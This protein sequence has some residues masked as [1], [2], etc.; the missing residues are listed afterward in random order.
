M[1][2]RLLIDFVNNLKTNDNANI[3]DAITEAIIVIMEEE[4]E[5]TMPIKN[6]FTLNKNKATGKI[7]KSKINTEVDDTDAFLITQM[8]GNLFN[9]D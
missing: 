5:E 4:P 3:I 2:T 7:N 1:N 6:R 8:A 9:I